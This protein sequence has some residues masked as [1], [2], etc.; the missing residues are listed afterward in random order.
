MSDPS[1]IVPARNITPLIRLI[2][3]VRVIVDADLARLYG[4][5]T[6][7]LNQA[8]KRNASRFPADF[9][10]RLTPA[11]SEALMRSQIVTTSPGLADPQALRSQIV[12]SNE[13]RG[14]RRYLPCYPQM[15]T[16]PPAPQA[17]TIA[18]HPPPA[19][20]GRKILAQGKAHGGPSAR[21]AAALGCV[22]QSIPS[23][24]R[25]EESGNANSKPLEFDGITRLSICAISTASRLRASR[26]TRK[27]A[28]PIR[29]S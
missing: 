21:T 8:V 25:A 10:F 28:K 9:L 26:P 29:I 4:V 7:A 23:P 16:P 2:R 27:S 18:A 6:K 14:G 5:P 12:T 11:E 13:K 19:P 22:P 20:K 15:R 3:E 17:R 24:E 1:R